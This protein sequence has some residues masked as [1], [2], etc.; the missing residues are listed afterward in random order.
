MSPFSDSD[1][2]RE[3][4]FSANTMQTRGDLVRTRQ[5]ANFSLTNQQIAW[6]QIKH[7][8]SLMMKKATDDKS[9]AWHNV[10]VILS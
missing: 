5:Q 10:C 2:L 1:W 6:Q 4:Q 9:N 8:Y 3:T 7:S